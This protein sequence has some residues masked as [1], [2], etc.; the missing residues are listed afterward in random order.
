DYLRKQ[1]DDSVGATVGTYTIIKAKNTR[2]PVPSL[3]EQER[4]VG[5]LDEAFAG[6]ATATANAEKNLQNARALFES[7]LE[8]VFTQ[9]GK[10][11]VEKALGRLPEWH[12]LHKEQPWRAGQNSWSERFQKPF[13]DASRKSR[14]CDA[15]WKAGRF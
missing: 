4:R 10:G 14:H 11:W 6:L 5:I 13:L 1:I 12:Q 3:S 2:I 8:S 9:R 15:R 7:H